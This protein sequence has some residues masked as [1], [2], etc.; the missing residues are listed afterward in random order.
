MIW[1]D[2]LSMD[3]SLE[4]QLIPVKSRTTEEQ[5]EAVQVEETPDEDDDHK[6]P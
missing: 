2:L 4:L 1:A 6:D 3:D 5:P